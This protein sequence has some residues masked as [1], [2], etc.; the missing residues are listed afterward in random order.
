M[1][2][3]P[4]ARATDT[5]V[6]PA[7][8]AGPRGATAAPAGGA[9]RARRRAL[10]VFCVVSVGLGWALTL[11]LLSFA[12]DQQAGLLAHALMVY[13]ISYAPAAAALL[14]LR[15]EAD[16]AARA[17]FWGRL[18]AWRRPWRWY[19]LALVLPPAVY[20]AGVGAAA[21]LA[22]GRVPFHPALLLALAYFLSASFGEEAG[23]RG[24]A[25][26][27]LQARFGALPASLL[28]GAL[29]ALFHLPANLT[30]APV[31]FVILTALLLATSVLMTWVFNRTGG[32]VPLVALVHASTDT[33]TL[34]SPLGETGTP[35]VAY[36]L[37]A[38]AMG[39]VAG[40]LVRRAGPAL[41]LPDAP[42]GGPP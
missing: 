35:V 19:L 16:S 36:A 22:G 20:L 40:L 2:P 38:A 11:L 31:Y 9:A 18:R 10:A 34:V 30:Q 24:Y 26:P 39:L 37:V 1:P 41:G 27:R 5:P 42:D 29:W 14:A 3:H 7:A 4:A 25:L 23:W 8:T 13:P 17:A 21:A 33:M 6:R 32:S 28:V 15:L 12:P